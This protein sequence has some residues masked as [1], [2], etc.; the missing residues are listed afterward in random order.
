[1]AEHDESHSP[2]PMHPARDHRTAERVMKAVLLVAAIAGV[3]LLL[4]MALAI[5]AYMMAG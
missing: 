2:F 3:V 1:M 4:P 5:S